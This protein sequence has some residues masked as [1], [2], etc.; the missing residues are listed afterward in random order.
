MS[1]KCFWF[2]SHLQILN[3]AGNVLTRNVINFVL[4]KCVIHMYTYFGKPQNKINEHSTVPRHSNSFSRRKIIIHRMNEIGNNEQRT[5]FA[6]TMSGSPCMNNNNQNQTD[7]LLWN[8]LD[9]G[10][11]IFIYTHR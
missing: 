3:K 1:T 9:I 11:W 6:L 4:S 10:Y 8:I 2:N 7:P 5:T